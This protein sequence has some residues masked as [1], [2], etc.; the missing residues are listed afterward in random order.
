MTR[1]LSCLWWSCTPPDSGFAFSSAEGTLS[2]TREDHD[3]ASLKVIQF[4]HEERVRSG[5]LQSFQSSRL[6][7][8]QS[9][10]K[11]NVVVSDISDAGVDTDVTQL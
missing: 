10:E 9:I 4:H 2:D 8:V 3:I 6:S 1:W 5:K 11:N 7:S